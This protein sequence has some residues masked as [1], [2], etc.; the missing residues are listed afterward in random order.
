M[1][2]TTIVA[3]LRQYPHH[4]TVQS[5]GLLALAHLLRFGENSTYSGTSGNGHSE[6]WTTSLQW[7]NCSPLPIYCSEEGATSEQW[8]K[9]LTPNVSIIQRFHCTGSY[10]EGG[11]GESMDH[12]WLSPLDSYA[13]ATVVL[14]DDHKLILDSLER[15]RDNQAVVVSALNALEV[16]T[17]I[18]TL[19]LAYYNTE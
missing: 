7:T 16:H 14:Q 19:Y 4:L 1:V 11:G 3:L 9:I 15:H 8:T 10:I 13:A 2:F 5:G 18:L 6:E 12:C 17:Y